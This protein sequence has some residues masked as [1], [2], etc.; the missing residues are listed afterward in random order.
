LNWKCFFYGGCNRADW[1]AAFL[2]NHPG[3]RHNV[4][5]TTNPQVGNSFR[6]PVAAA[7][8]LRF[9]V[10]RLVAT[11]RGHRRQKKRHEVEAM[12]KSNSLPLCENMSRHAWTTSP[13]LQLDAGV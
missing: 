5:N 13:N 4:E 8:R 1:A 3:K 10:M 7:K 9:Q 6:P 12:N 11:V 2:E